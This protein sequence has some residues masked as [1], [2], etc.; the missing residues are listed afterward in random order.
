M[1]LVKLIGVNS[2]WFHKLNGIAQAL[3]KY[4]TRKSAEVLNDGGLQIRSSWSEEY[5][6]LVTSCSNWNIF[7]QQEESE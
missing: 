5:E 3:T 7:I 2:K 4:T 6:Q 1:K